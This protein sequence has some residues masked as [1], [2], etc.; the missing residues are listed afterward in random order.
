MS[1]FNAVY[2]L[3]VQRL[4]LVNLQV[5]EQSYLGMSLLTQGIWE[6]SRKGRLN[7]TFLCLTDLMQ[8]ANVRFSRKRNLNQSAGVKMKLV[9]QNIRKLSDIMNVSRKE[10]CDPR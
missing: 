5:S 7:L 9:F 6:D 2:Q 1:K 8:L 3:L 10:D 4:D